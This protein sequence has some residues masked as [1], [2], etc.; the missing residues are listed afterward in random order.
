MDALNDCTWTRI[1]SLDAFERRLVAL[2]PDDWEA[3]ARNRGSRWLWPGSRMTR[4][5]GD[6]EPPPLN[7]F[8]RVF[9][10]RSGRAIAATR[11]RYRFLRMPRRLIKWSEAAIL[12]DDP[13]L[14]ALIPNPN[15]VRA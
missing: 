4:I 8:T 5:E 1:R 13:D 10:D 3:D 14:V 15:G 11:R 2:R 12:V 6:D 7:G 9:F